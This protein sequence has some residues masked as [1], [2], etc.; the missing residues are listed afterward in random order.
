MSDD[1]RRVAVVTGASSGIGAA[2]ARVLAETGFDVVLGARRVDRIEALA[3][4]IGGRAIRLDVSDIDSVRAFAGQVPR[5]NVLVNNAGGAI[6]L[7]PIAEARTEDWVTM[8]ESNV[9]G[10]MFMTREFLPKLEASGDGHIVNMGSIAGLEG[11][12]GGGGYNAAKFGTRAITHVLR[13]ELLG[14]PIRVTEVD[15]GMVATEEFSVVRFRGDVERAKKVYENVVPLVAEDIADIVGYACTR[16]SH[17]NI[18]QVVAKPVAQ[19]NAAI[20]HRGDLGIGRS[21]GRRPVAVITGAS[22][23]IGAATARWLAGA[24]WEVVLGARRLDRIEALAEEIGARGLPLDVTDPESVKQFA[25]KIPAVDLLVN[26]AGMARA[27]VPI[28]EA[29]L[30]DWEAVW[31]TN[32]LGLV[33]VTRRFLPKL[34]ESGRGHVIN[35]GSVTGFETQAGRGSYNTTKFAVRAI[36]G[37]LRHE[38]NGTPVRVSEVDP[39]LVESEFALVRTGGDEAAARDLFRGLRALD[40]EDLGDVVGWVAT[41]PPHVNLE[42]VVVKPLAQASVLAVHRERV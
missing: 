21:N 1:G 10:L 18:D 15:P 3:K 22:S 41:R 35:I 25:E 4:E 30:E 12:K 14:K 23:G 42:Q 16:P 9:L 36:T 34:L 38:L 32:V 7:D 13:L 17:V 29:V 40:A 31:R 20:V 19:Y 27:F 11:Y 6:G 5:I 2:S 28:A 8:F 26:N 24:G 37:T 39:G 33:D